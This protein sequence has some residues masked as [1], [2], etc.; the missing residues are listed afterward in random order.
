M[1][2]PIIE[3]LAKKLQGDITFAKLDVD[4]NP[5]T[6]QRFSIQTIPNLLIFKNG[7][8]VGDII[9]ALPEAQL[10]KELNAYR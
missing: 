9:G 6:A 2:G 7:R 10:L 5:T 8:K 1:L 3:S 4:A